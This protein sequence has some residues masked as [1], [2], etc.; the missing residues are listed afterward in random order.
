[1]PGHLPPCHLYATIAWV[2]VSTGLKLPDR[3]V[4]HLHLIS[5]IQNA[6]TVHFHGILLTHMGYCLHE[7]EVT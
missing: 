1:M 5:V 2:A 3:D 4:T 6:W 7:A